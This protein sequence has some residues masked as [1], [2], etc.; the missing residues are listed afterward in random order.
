METPK[1]K[2]KIFKKRKWLRSIF[3]TL[4]V[5]VFLPTGL[6]TIG[7]L[8]RDSVIEVLQEWYRKNNTGTLTIGKVNADF[9]RGFPNV[10]FTLTEI[11][12]TN[13]D[14]ITDEFSKIHIEEAK[15]V[16]RA[17]DILT[18]NL[19][20]KK[21]SIK[22]A[23]ISSVI[24]SRKSL[25][26]HER[27]KSN[28]QHQDFNL[29]SWLDKKGVNFLLENVTYS[30]I[31]SVSNQHFNFEIHKIKGQFKGKDNQLVGEASLDL[32]V[33]NLGFNTKKGSF[34]NGAHV[35]GKP[36]FSL[37]L[38]K[39]V[40]EVSEFIFNVDA[41]AFRLYAYFDLSKKDEYLFRLKNDETD[42][43]AV[44][45]LLTDSLAVKIKN[46]QILKPFS[47]DLK[48]AGKFAHGNDPDIEVKYSTIDN[49]IIIADQF[50]F[51]NAAFSGKLSTDI[52]ETE[53]LKVAKKTGYDIK[54]Q[55]DSITANLENIKVDIRNGFYQ[56]T[57]EVWNFVQA[58][59]RLKGSNDALTKIIEMENFNLEGG[60]FNLDVAISGDIPNAYQ[61]LNKATGSFN[62]E[63]SRVILK[64]NGLQLPIQSI[65]LTLNRENSSLKQFI[66][67]LPNGENLILKGE[68]K[69]IS[70]IISNTPTIPTTSHISLNSQSLNINEIL[71]L[72]KQ[73]SS[74]TASNDQTDL[75][76]TLDAIY[77]QFHP[78]FQ[79]NV[80][81]LKYNDVVINNLKSNIALVN[82]E[83]ILLKNFDFNYYE[84]LTSLKGNVTVHGPEST[85]KNVI[86]MNAEATSSGPISILRDLFDIEL[87][88]IDSGDYKF[89]GKVTGNIK[90]FSELLKNAQGDLTLKDTKLYYEP[91]DIAVVIDSLALFLDHSNILLNKFN[92]KIDEQYSINLNGNVK[93]FPSFLLDGEKKKGSIYLK[94]SAPFVDGDDL[95][96]TINSF[97]EEGVNKELGKKRA[98]HKVFKD[99][100]R[101]N[102][103]IELAID[104]L[105]YNTLITEQ[106]KA[107]LYFENDTILKLQTLDL[108]YKS[109]T[110]NVQGIVNSHTSKKDLKNENP[111]DID[112]RVKVKGKA[113][114][115]N[116]YLKTKNFIFKSGDFEFKGEY[117]GQ[118]EELAILNSKTFGDLKISKALVDYKAAG[119]KIPV[120]SLHIEINDD[121]ATLKTLDID[122]PGKSS[123][124]FSGSID[125][126]SN[127]INDSI[128]NNLH[129]ST[130]SIYSPYLDSDDIK[131][132]LKN[133]KSNDDN[134]S[135]EDMSLIKIKEAMV[136]INAS[137][138]PTVD[139]KIDTLVH[140]DF[141][142]TD[143]GL[144]LLF[145]NP[146]NFKIKDTKLDFYGGSIVMNVD[147]GLET[148]EQT[149]VKIMMDAQNVNIH[150]LVTRFDYFNDDALRKVEKI[151]GK[152]NYR[153]NAN[154]TLNDNGKVNMGSLNG[155][156]ELEL[157]DFEL[158]NYQPIMENSVLMKN[159]RFKNLRFRPIV[160]TFE[161]ID[162]VLIIPRTEIQTSALHVFVEGNLK[163]ND[164]MNIWVSIPWK[165]LKANDG[166]SF[167]EKTTYR[168]AGSKFFVQ[169]LQDKTKEKPRNQKLKFK[170]RLSNRKLKKLK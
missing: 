8:N 168:A 126:F 59:I 165:N 149:P 7:W 72:A 48:L 123:M 137:Y 71:S 143:F 22:N 38:R 106:L 27:L 98:L 132:F 10:G 89:N 18:G 142:L 141:S 150:E 24:V 66:I 78:E 144:N 97:R 164:Y 57:P 60:N 6:F 77:S 17:G 49:E 13:N 25:E 53:A 42:F 121:L 111:F 108:R 43:K 103:K 133:T 148:G 69:N 35:T 28:A 131:V 162:G 76:E 65:D 19:K 163:F 124:Y 153:I 156:F 140:K 74:K 23:V 56:S 109:T 64:K 44:K 29:P 86:S 90:E 34:F 39:D 87:F 82:S 101:F 134:P 170:V 14:T 104:T 84:S 3:I 151:E 136:K 46:Y 157:E 169:L 37:N 147:V 99:I 61:F 16:I 120:D 1:S 26:Y 116:D 50:N 161:I 127:F 115:L 135:A 92:V 32:N 129:S 20:F 114:D 47:T 105:K 45:G 93:Q 138:Y 145:D 51:K 102:P 158:Y 55:F 155:T 167:P 40:I 67:N 5:L 122:L 54:I 146:T 79:I 96:A 31:D 112:F 139:V 4:A 9:F 159:E 33:H 62:L 91:A 12:H 36:K 15:I 113:E 94:I 118:S 100:N 88:R 130:F 152:L 83:T 107:Q 119:L 117:R 80:T 68:L 70:G 41:Q 128:Q 85:L 95:L 52:Y 160:Q 30:A 63:N 166:L 154:G 58:N 81:S 75:Y 2:V 125:N 11:N 110:A 73:F 21:I